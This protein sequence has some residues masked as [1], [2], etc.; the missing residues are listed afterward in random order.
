VVSGMDDVRVESAIGERIRRLR[1][2][3]LM[4]Q[5]DLAAAADGS[6][7][8]IRKLEQASGIPPR[9]GACT[10]LRRRLMSALASC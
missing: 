6:T 7:D 2:D 10:A 5:D 1:K 9:S 3:A 4:T 8:L